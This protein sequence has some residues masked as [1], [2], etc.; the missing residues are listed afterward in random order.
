MSGALYW[1][2]LRAS[3]KALISYAVSLV[4]YLWLIIGIFPTVAHSQAL[5]TVLKGL[6]AG[7]LKAL[8]YQ[9]GATHL[10]G[11]LAGEFYG[12]IYLVILGIYA[13]FTATRLMAHWVEVIGQP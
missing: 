5:R 6:P 7:M 9:V 13:L 12:L 4:L 1:S 3:A 8:G 10:A 2:V 11:F